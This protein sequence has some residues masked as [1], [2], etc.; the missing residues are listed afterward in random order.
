[1]V[2]IPERTLFNQISK[3]SHVIGSCLQVGS[4]RFCATPF[5][6][7]WPRMLLQSFPYQRRRKEVFLGKPCFSQTSIQ[8]EL[9]E[10]GYLTNHTFKGL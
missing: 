9:K 6:G 1:M 3:V 2:S 10:H 8:S 5:N 4:K 7:N